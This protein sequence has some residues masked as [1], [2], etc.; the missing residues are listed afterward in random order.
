MPIKTIPQLLLAAIIT[1]LAIW[2]GF[3][4][5]ELLRDFIL[6]GLILC[7]VGLAIAP[8]LRH[9]RVRLA[10]I[11]L[12]V[13]ILAAAIFVYWRAIM[14]AGRANAI[15]ALQTQYPDKVPMWSYI[16]DHVPA[17]APLAYTNLVF[18]RPLMGF[19]YSRSVFYIP[20]RP[21]LQN[22]HDLP[23]GNAHI[24]DQQ[25]RSFIAQLL[26]EN[27]DQNLWLANILQSNAQY[28]LVGTPIRSD[29][30]ELAFAESD[31]T[32]FHREFWMNPAPTKSSD[33]LQ[34]NHDRISRWVDSPSIY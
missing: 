15:V 14:D 22:Y 5:K 16:A 4:D 30:P 12:V 8:A 33:N 21:G 29:P 7:I 31:P 20:T 32:H 25:I 28:L 17:D 1:A 19:D 9:A 2:G 34:Q 13:L 23:P 3:N 24:T 6:T 27:P 10:A 18:T 26:T 11:S